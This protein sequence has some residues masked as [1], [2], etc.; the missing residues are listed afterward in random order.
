MFVLIL[1][2]FC[3]FLLNVTPIFELGFHPNMA[4]VNFV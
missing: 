1:Y 3:T 2:F 4:D